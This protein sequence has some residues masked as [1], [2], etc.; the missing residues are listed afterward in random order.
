MVTYTSEH[1]IKVA[2]YRPFSKMPLKWHFAGGPIVDQTLRSRLDGRFKKKLKQKFYLSC[3]R[4]KY[5]E[6]SKS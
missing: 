4:V 5:I 1:N 3:F 6:K 2:H